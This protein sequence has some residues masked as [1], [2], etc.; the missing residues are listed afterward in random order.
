[1]SLYWE[2][3]GD[4][5][6]VVSILNQNKVLLATSDTVLGLLAPL[7]QTGYDLLNT[8]KQREKMPYLVLI[9][10]KNKL[11]YF[12]DQ[13]LS[14]KVR[15]LIEMSWPGPVTFI[16]KARTT[17]P[18]YLKSD[19]GTIALRLPDHKGLRSLLQ[20]YNGLFSTSANMHKEPIP[21]SIAEVNSAILQH[22][23]GICLDEQSHQNDT[24]PSSIIDCSDQDIKVIRAG[25]KM[26][27]LLSFLG[28]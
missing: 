25:A 14:P 12:I 17:L 16:F 28:K 13:E 8:I 11:D 4:I 23:G 24:T 21:T 27:E 22:I 10:S 20:E 26:K 19:Q 9:G 6:E 18:H 3:Q 1:M 2:K 5:K 15:Q 7:N